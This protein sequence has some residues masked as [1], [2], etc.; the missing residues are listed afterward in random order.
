M[1]LIGT[2]NTAPGIVDGMAAL[3]RGGSAMD[4][5]EITLRAVESDPLEDSVGYGGLPNLLGEVELDASIMDGSS[6]R[7]GAVAALKGYLHPISVARK[8]MEMLPHVLLVGSGAARFAAEIGAEAGDLLTDSAAAKYRERLSAA[9]LT[10]SLAGDDGSVSLSDALWRVLGYRSHG[11][12]NAIAID[13]EGHICCGVTT[14]GWAFKYPGRVGDSPIIG[15]GGYADDRYGACA[16]TGL[17]EASMRL[18]TAYSVVAGLAGGRQLDDCVESA[19]RELARLSS[20]VPI[21]M[22]ILAL[23][24]LG[25]HTY[26]STHTA[27]RHYLYMRPDDS[28][29]QRGLA[30]GLADDAGQ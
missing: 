26:W 25:Q 8:V 10:E 4:A 21:G 19:M 6:L 12:S 7:A 29:P 3:R 30:K 1:I 15:A 22:N 28:E 24:R 16:C 2:A 9:S 20:P 14:S 27:D 13:R 11:T 18:C 5:V 17:G 23:D